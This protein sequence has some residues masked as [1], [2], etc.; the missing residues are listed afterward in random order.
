M[1]DNKTVNQPTDIC[2]KCGFNYNTH[3]GISRYCPESAHGLESRLATNSTFTPKEDHEAVHDKVEGP[4]PYA[5]SLDEALTQNKLLHELNQRMMNDGFDKSKIWQYMTEAEVSRLTA[6]EIDIEKFWK[7]QAADLQ[8]VLEKMKLREHE[9]EAERDA[10]KAA[11]TDA[12]KTLVDIAEQ[13]GARY[14][15]TKLN[16]RIAALLNKTDKP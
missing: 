12:Q 7:P 2:A 5:R 9:L 16:E 1:S 3:T 4:K 13:F 6:Y 14:T 8:A 10:L 11:L 15:R